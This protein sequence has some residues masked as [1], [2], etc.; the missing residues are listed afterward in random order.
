MRS[1]EELVDAA[2]ELPRAD[3]ERL[4]LE[5]SKL[6]EEHEPASDEHGR[7]GLKGFL[8][9]AGRAEATAEDVASDKYRHLAEIYSSD[10]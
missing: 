2:R 10:E 9:L 5:I 4:V 3:R 6:V 1:V 8:S 7:H